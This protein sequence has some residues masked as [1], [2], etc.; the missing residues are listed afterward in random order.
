MENEELVLKRPVFPEERKMGDCK[1]WGRCTIKNWERGFP[2]GAVV[3]NLPCN[4]GD[5]SLIPGWETKIPHQFQF[6]HSVVSDSLW[7]HGLQHARLLC[8]SPT[9]GACSNS[10]PPSWWCHPTILSSVI[11]FSSRLQSFPASGSF[12]M[13]QFFI[14]GGRSIGVS[15]SASVLPM[16]T[17]DW[18]PLG[19]T[20]W[21]S[22]P[23]AADQL[24]FGP[25]TTK[26][27]HH[28]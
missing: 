15:A 21:I 18:L 13:S 8:P 23:H 5:A 11:P 25:P 28:N 22:F 17:Q 27:L 24:S 10:C 9:T 3:K 19:W 1:E 6:S 20:G 26:P 12:P 16:N 7:P 2:D 4:A 14:S